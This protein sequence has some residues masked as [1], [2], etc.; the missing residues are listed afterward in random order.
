MSPQLLA[1][2]AHGWGDYILQSHWMATV[3]TQRSIAAAAHVATYILPFL[4][5]TRSVPALAVIAGTHFVIDR[6]RLARHVIWVKNWLAP[7]GH[8]PRP[9]AEC[10]AT[11][12]NPD[13][14]PWLS[15]WLLIAADNLMHITIN[16]LVVYLWVSL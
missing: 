1:L 15:V 4:I 14:P 16:A 9:W 8:R 2:L 7:P 5:V 11:G 6:W 12:Y 10:T 3:K 13:V